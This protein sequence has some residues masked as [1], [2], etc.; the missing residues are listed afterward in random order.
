MIDKN[1]VNSEIVSSRYPDF[2][3]MLATCQMNPTQEEYNQC[4]STFPILL[5]DFLDQG[6]IPDSKFEDLGFQPD[7]DLNGVVQRREAG[8]ENE[9]RQQVKNLTHHFQVQLRQEKLA[10]I[11]TKAAHKVADARKK[12]ETILPGNKKCEDII[13]QNNAS[14]H[15]GTLEDLMIKFRDL[16][17]DLCKN[18]IQV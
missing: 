3:K 10:A 1:V 14:L 6:H 13:T 11:A 7:V 16:K 4:V 8:I 18:F 9:S 15:N 5:R 17:N 2:N 12:T